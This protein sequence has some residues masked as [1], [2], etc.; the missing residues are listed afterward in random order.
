MSPFPP[1][2]QAFVR[3]LTL[4]QSFRLTLLY[5]THVRRSHGCLP[6]SQPI[7]SF[8]FFSNIAQRREKSENGR[9]RHCLRIVENAG[10]SCRNTLR[11]IFRNFILTFLSRFSTP[12][13]GKAN[14]TMRGRR[15]GRGRRGEAKSKRASGRGRTR[16]DRGS[17]RRG[18]NTRKRG[19]IPR[20]AGNSI[21]ITYI[22][23]IFVL[24][25]FKRSS[26]KAPDRSGDG[27][28]GLS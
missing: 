16:L 5:L 25:R 3:S 20:D 14:R 8:S 6:A 9:P 15:S 17:R 22:C 2:V 24:G 26:G 23:A 27:R 21:R 10:Q 13:S 1:A 7:L 11:I 18:E 28:E 12:F 4:S 19:K